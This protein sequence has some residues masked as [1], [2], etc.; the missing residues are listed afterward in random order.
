MT[1]D[2]SI[3]GVNSKNIL[4]YIPLEMKKRLKATDT[5]FKRRILRTPWTDNV[6][7]Y[8]ILEK[9]EARM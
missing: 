1:N 3:S 8:E 4:L 9:I 6:I 5:S 7:S 2:S